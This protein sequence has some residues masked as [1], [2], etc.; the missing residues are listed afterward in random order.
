MKILGVSSSSSS[1]G[2]ARILSV[3]APKY[4][5]TH[6]RLELLQFEAG[7]SSKDVSVATSGAS[8]GP[9]SLFGFP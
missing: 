3:H 9:M 2:R 7:V 6:H 8:L 5:V 1:V 4:P